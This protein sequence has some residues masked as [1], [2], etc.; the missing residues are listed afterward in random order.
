MQYS[1]LDVTSCF[2]TQAKLGGAGATT[3]VSA[4][5]TTGTSSSSTNKE[6]LDGVALDVTFGRSD[7]NQQ[8]FL[9]ES[10]CI[11]AFP[12]FDDGYNNPDCALMKWDSSES[13]VK[14]L[15]GIFDVPYFD[16]CDGSTDSNADHC[17]PNGQVAL[18]GTF[19]APGAGVAIDDQGYRS[20]ALSG[21]A[22]GNGSN[23]YFGVNYSIFDRGVIARSV[24]FN[25]F[26]AVAGYTGAIIAC[27]GSNGDPNDNTCKGGQ[28]TTG[29][30]ETLTSYVCPTTT[31]CSATGGQK[32]VTAK[33]LIPAD[34]SA[35]KIT[36]WNA[37]QEP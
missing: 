21:C 11:T 37:N 19:Y 6:H 7:P 24:R 10:G 32:R 17:L 1:P 18:E 31:D 5:Y 34:Q 33:I 9:P 14:A 2:N 22:D 36:S 25:S 3:T 30:E 35:P 13:R 12:N 23:C 20:T 26:K 4:L 27:A 15:F 16:L 28:I 29:Y 8:V